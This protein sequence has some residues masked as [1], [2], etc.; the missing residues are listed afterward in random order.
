MAR[1]QAAK[2]E[3]SGHEREMLEKIVRS[4]TDTGGMPPRPGPDRAC[5]TGRVE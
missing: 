3:L 2:I 5:G 1:K 4:V